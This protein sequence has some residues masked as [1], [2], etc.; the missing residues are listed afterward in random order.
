M[1]NKLA[2]TIALAGFGIITALGVGFAGADQLSG[3]D[4]LETATPLPATPAATP[5]AC[6]NELDDDGDGLFDA[7]DSDCASPTDPSEEPAP[8][9]E[10]TPNSNVEAPPSSPAAAPQH[11]DFEAGATIG[12]GSADA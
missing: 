6:S 3:G 9:A 7:D 11:S 4:V 8:A 2:L 10:A 1:R 12:G 5:P